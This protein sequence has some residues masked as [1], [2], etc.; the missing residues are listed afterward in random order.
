[1]LKNLT[2]IIWFISLWIASLSLVWCFHVPDEDWLPSKDKVDTWNIEKENEM[3]QAINSFMDWI[4]MI[5]SE[6]NEMKNN[7]ENDVDA[8]NLKIDVVEMEENIESEE[9]VGNEEIV[10][11]VDKVVDNEG[12]HQEIQEEIIFEEES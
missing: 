1:M 8:E 3:E 9:N 10:E 2:K 6:W 11:N 12:E 4:D 7:E 5:S